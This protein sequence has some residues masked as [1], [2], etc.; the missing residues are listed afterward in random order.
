M[1]GRPDYPGWISRELLVHRPCVDA[2]HADSSPIAVAWIRLA[3]TL[4]LQMRQH[5]FF[6]E[7]VLN[8]LWQVAPNPDDRL[9]ERA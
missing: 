9:S 5:R 8:V 7:V 4:L 6:K 2:R 1:A 3:T